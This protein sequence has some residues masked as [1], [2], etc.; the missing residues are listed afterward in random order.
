MKLK[1][2]FILDPALRLYLPL[3]KLDGN[4]FQ[5]KDAY[6]HL[7]TVTGATK[8]LQGFSFDGVDDKITIPH[9]ATLDFGLTSFWEMMV[10]KLLTLREQGLVSKY[11]AVS[12]KGEVGFWMGAA[13]GN[14]A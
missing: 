7:A 13:G 11:D 14:S 3:W 4:S 8:V 9:A 2:S 1:R 5:S 12:P 6:G 10:F